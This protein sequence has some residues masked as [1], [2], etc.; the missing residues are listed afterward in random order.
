MTRKQSGEVPQ[1][2]KQPVSKAA[3][4]AQEVGRD[5]ADVHSVGRGRVKR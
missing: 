4:V 2:E 5:R 3:R 1:E